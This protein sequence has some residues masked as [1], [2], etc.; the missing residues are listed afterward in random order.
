MNVDES[1]EE[2]EGENIGT[3]L[4]RYL[5]DRVEKKVPDVLKWWHEHRQTYPRLW[6]MARNFV[7]IPGKSSNGSRG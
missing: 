2:D 5:K 7:L 6:R 1:N 3:E 4:E